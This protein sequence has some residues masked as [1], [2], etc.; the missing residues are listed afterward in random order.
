MQ[1]QS[2]HWKR[3]QWTGSGTSWFVDA[4]AIEIHKVF[5][6][7][8]PVVCHEYE[9]IN[10]SGRIRV[11]RERLIICL[12]PCYVRLHSS[13]SV[14][15][16]YQFLEKISSFSLKSAFRLVTFSDSSL[17]RSSL[18]P[19]RGLRNRKDILTFS[20]LTLCYV[21]TD[22]LY[23]TFSPL[24]CPALPCPDLANSVY[25]SSHATS[26]DT[27]SPWLHTQN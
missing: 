9:T 7:G 3:S 15:L 2:S 17:Y 24:S 22:Y 18:W 14:Y 11:N 13:I 4:G 23:N 21:A 20:I 25:N 12:Q 26:L 1:A 19:L 27:L 8:Q 5:K 16:I 10:W 6:P